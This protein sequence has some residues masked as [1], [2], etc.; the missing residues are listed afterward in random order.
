MLAA[1]WERDQARRW[2]AAYDE[3]QAAGEYGE[4]ARPEPVRLDPAN[5]AQAC[6]A[7]HG[8]DEDRDDLGLGD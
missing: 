3:R 6:L 2:L 4:V 1:R 5:V 8:L 7:G